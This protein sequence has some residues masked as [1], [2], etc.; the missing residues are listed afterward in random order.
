MAATV[1]GVDD[2]NTA[3]H[4]PGSSSGERFTVSSTFGVLLR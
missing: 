3:K 1:S 4:P 2:H